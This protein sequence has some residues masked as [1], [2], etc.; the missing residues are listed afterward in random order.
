SLLAFALL[1][2]IAGCD[3]SPP[4]AGTSPDADPPS[5]AVAESREAF[6]AISANWLDRGL[7]FSPVAATGIGDHR[8]DDRVDDL[9]AAGRAAAMEWNR[10]VLAD[11]VTIDVSRL[12]REDQV[13]AAILRNQLEYAIWDEE[14][15]QRWAWDPQMYASLTGGAIYSLM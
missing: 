7:A 13:D 1:A 6:A 14:V 10:A 12:S 3:R 15:M 2:A 4:V 8:F 9:R 5:A 11:L